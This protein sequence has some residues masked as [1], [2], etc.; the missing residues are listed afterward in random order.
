MLMLR[1]QKK[2][3]VGLGFNISRTRD[4]NM[5]L[6]PQFVLLAQWHNFLEFI[7]EWQ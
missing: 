2:Y 1:I 4:S 5:V 3:L 7:S 6:K